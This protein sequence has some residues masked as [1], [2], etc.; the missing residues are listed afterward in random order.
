MTIGKL[1][2]FF[3]EV[4]DN[5]YCGDSS[6]NL[7]GLS[8]LREM[9][10]SSNITSLQASQTATVVAIIPQTASVMTSHQLLQSAPNPLH[11]VSHLQYSTAVGATSCNTD[12]SGMNGGGS[13]AALYKFKNNIKQR[14]TA[15]HIDDND[16]KNGHCDED[17]AHTN[18]CP[19]N[20]SGVGVK[21]KHGSVEPS[22]ELLSGNG[23]AAL[24]S[25]TNLKCR[26]SETC[27]I[28][29]SPPSPPTS[30]YPTCTSSPDHTHTP[31]PLRSLIN[32]S[33]GVP[34]FALHSKG[35]FYVPL[36]LDAEVLAPYLAA[37]GFGPGV[38]SIQSGNTS[39][40]S[41]S[42]VLHPVTISVNF[43]QTNHHRIH[44]HHSRQHSNLCSS[45]TS[46]KNELNAFLPMW[47]AYSPDRN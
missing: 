39:S 20:K 47:S 40:V 15:E 26:D 5:S 21:R 25:V 18:D 29:S 16:D 46:W 12:Q 10:T 28:P 37:I 22:H 42:V 43:Q 32:P 1:S 14:F 33:Y 3:T 8:Q 27:S 17:A 35:S 9:L 2:F 38:S 4:G 23:T 6:A 34:I 11:T 31:P 45:M 13:A 36:T 41:G 24:S 7:H 44:Q 30:K 19:I